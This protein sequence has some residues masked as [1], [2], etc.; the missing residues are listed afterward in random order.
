VSYITHSLPV[1]PLISSSLR[2]TDLTDP[3]VN[4]T[5]FVSQSGIDVHAGS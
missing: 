1:S 4:W 2:S 5:I 3:N